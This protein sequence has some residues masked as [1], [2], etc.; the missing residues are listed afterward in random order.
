MAA[1]A[2]AT[3]SARRESLEC[4]RRQLPHEGL[5]VIECAR[6]PVDVLGRGDAAEHHGCVA[7]QPRSFARVLGEPSSA[8][9]YSS[10]MVPDGSAATTLLVGSPVVERVTWLG[11]GAPHEFAR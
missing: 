2:S 9:L 10:C 7:V 4:A 8:A 1:G 11:P 6:E 5:R 3:R